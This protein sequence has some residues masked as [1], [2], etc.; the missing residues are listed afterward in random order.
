MQRGSTRSKSRWPRPGPSWRKGAPGWSSASAPPWRHCPTARSPAR[1]WLMPPA[2][3]SKPMS[4]AAELARQRARDRAAQRTLTGP[5]RDE[6]E[7]MLAGKGMLAAS[8]STGE[9]KAMLIAITLAH[10]EL[11]AAGRPGVLL[12]DEVAAHLDPLRR[13]ALF[14][15]LRGSGAQAWLTG[16]E[17][18]PFAGIEGEAAVWRVAGVRSSGWASPLSAK[19]RRRRLW[20]RRPAL[21][22]L[23]RRMDAVALDQRGLVVDRF[24]EERH[25]PRAMALGERR[26]DRI[27]LGDIV[28]RRDWAVHA[29]PSAGPGC[30][31]TP[32]QRGSLRGSP[33]SPPAGGRAAGR[34]RRARRRRGRARARGRRARNRGVAVPP[35]KYHPRRRRWSRAR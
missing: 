10:A 11:A 23:G 27:E 26:I 6:L 34:C 18:A 24:E 25:Q 5:H 3:R 12:L 15:R 16:T 7:V 21:R 4:L 1:R 17:L 35:P 9:Q 2:V 29:C 8:C 31:A 28:P 20:S 33:A 22:S 30:C 19:L 13:E 14:E 32:G